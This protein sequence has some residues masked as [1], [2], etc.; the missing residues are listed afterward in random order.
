MKKLSLELD[1]LGVESFE[2]E[3]G[4]ARGSVKGNAATLRCTNDCSAGCLPTQCTCGADP[5]T[6]A[7][8]D[9]IT[10]CMCCA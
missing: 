1:E 9:A 6:N 10:N 4:E 3:A 7:M 8:Q 2:T 5:G